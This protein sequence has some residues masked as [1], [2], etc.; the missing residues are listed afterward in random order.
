MEWLFQCNPLRYNLEEALRR[1]PEDNWAVNQHRDQISVGDRIFFWESGETACLSVVGHVTSP[2]YD[3]GEENQLGRYG[4]HVVYER[5]F[6]PPVTRREILADDVLSHFRPFTRAE[7]TNFPI[8]DER[9]VRT[10]GNLMHDRSVPIELSGPR[11]RARRYLVCPAVQRAAGIHLDRSV[12]REIT[13]DE[14]LRYMGPEETSRVRSN[15]N[16]RALR[17]WGLSDPTKSYFERV[18]SNDVVLFYVRQNNQPGF[19]HACEVITKSINADL[20][21]YLWGTA[22]YSLILVL[23]EPADRFISLAEFNALGGREYVTVPHA[24][25]LANDSRVEALD[26]FYDLAFSNRSVPP[27]KD[28]RANR[29]RAIQD[30]ERRL[31]IERAAIKA[32]MDYYEKNNFKIVSRELEKV[33]WDLEA[34]GNATGEVLYVEVKGTD[35]KDFLVELTP[36]EYRAL[37]NHRTRYR[38]AIVSSALRKE[39]L[40]LFSYSADED[41]WVDLLGAG[42]LDIEERVAARLSSPVTN[43]TTIDGLL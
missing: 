21:Q 34:V 39:I 7:G 16:G 8:T 30:V 40:H 41:Q 4:V 27:P 6:E 11:K 31:K 42:V 19:N 15:A 2:V 3:R 32:V 1:G 33:G 9:V 10:L 25:I 20:S 38:V 36:N 37:Q 26:R 18:Q 12:R 13:L 22:E 43:E 23:G 24:L 14:I 17:V 35:A 28:A 5:T 29:R